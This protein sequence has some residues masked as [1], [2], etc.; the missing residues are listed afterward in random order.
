MA[1]ETKSPETHQFQA[2]IKHLLDI[3]INSLYTHREIFVR[4]L[5][6][7]A[8]DALERFRHEQLV[9]KDLQYDKA[10]LEIH[11]DLDKEAKTFRITD[12]GDGMTREQLAENLG[13]IAHSGTRSF[14]SRLADS[15]QQD[16]N[17]IG[18]FGV[19]FYS[20]FMVAKKVTVET[21][22]YHPDSPGWRWESDGAGEYTISPAEDLPRGTRITVELKDDCEEYADDFRIKD[23]VRQFSNF[24]AFPILVNSEKVNTIQAIWLRNKNDVKDEEYNEFYKFIGN[25][26]DE[27]SYR[28]H[29]SADAPLAINALLFV[30]KD[31][32]ERFGFGRTKPGVDLHCRR[33]LIMKQPEELLPEWMRFVKGVIDSEDLPLNISRETLQD[34]SL[35][36]KLSRVITGRFI[37]F[38]AEQAKSD[39]EKYAEFFTT[40]GGF[41]KEGA[42]QDFAHREDLAKLLRF[43][44][45]KTEKGKMT[46]LA[47]YLS[48]MGDDQKQIYYIN[49]P[50]REAIEAG[51]YVEAFKARDLEVLY[52]YEPIDDFV[53]SNLGT[54][55]EKELVSAD[56][57]D[58]ELPGEAKSEGEELSTEAA[59][60]LC[61]WLKSTL[62]ETRVHE[63][64]SSKRLV[65]SP[66]AATT[67]GPMS[68]AM[69]RMMMSI[70]RDSELN[71]QFLSLEINPRH[72]LVHRLNALRTENEDF[73]KDLAEQLYDNA[74]LAAGLLTDPRSMVERLNKLLAK[75]A[76]A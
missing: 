69:Q 31:N 59:G 61:G 47:E 51:P 75:A 76:G 43:E 73:A 28:M 29:F 8:A 49:G 48:R 13:T 32:F 4:E 1:T 21:K 41:I 44:S 74:L 25:S 15:A 68:S 70:N 56:R 45:S 17:L 71:T 39:E 9:N 65:D 40:F 72:A 64:K 50:S 37:K 5:I 57:G 14:L 6:S 3:V 18:Q 27:P 67:Q 2:E 26:T 36:R 55:E 63:V 30:P 12:T 20:A 24:V 33:V 42:A 22:S 11:I 52:L 23:V 34:S 35:V 66:A 7:N 10:P 60:E 62:G 53:M 54:F 46:S 16:V 38:L 58:L 19:G